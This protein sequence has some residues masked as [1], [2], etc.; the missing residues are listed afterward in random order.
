MLTP[1]L[2]VLKFVC[3]CFFLFLILLWTVLISLDVS[4]CQPGHLKCTSSDHCILL[5]WVCDGGD[6][7]PDGSDEKSCGKDIRVYSDQNKS[8]FV[9]KLIQQ[10]FSAY[11]SI[12]NSLL[13]LQFS[14]SD[15]FHKVTKSNIRLLLQPL[16]VTSP[17]INCP[18]FAKQLTENVLNSIFNSLV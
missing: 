4:G 16:V 18:L 13:S 12:S 10:A 7:C 6:D 1:S 17:P 11:R 2:I 15:L 3:F 5:R 8:D 9:S 14:Y